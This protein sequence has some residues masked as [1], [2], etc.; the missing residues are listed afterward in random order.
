MK[1]VE[2]FGHGVGVHLDVG[3]LRFVSL[4]VDFEIAFCCE[5]IATYI[6]FEGTFARMGPDVDLQSRVTA[7]HFAAELTPVPIHRVLL[8]IFGF[9]KA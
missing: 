8:S 1:L 7:E 2:M 6:A 5:S 9:A 4:E 3:V